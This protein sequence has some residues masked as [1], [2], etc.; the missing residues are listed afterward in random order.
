MR[1]CEEQL[2]LQRSFGWLLTVCS[3]LATI[4]NYAVNAFF[5]YISDTMCKNRLYKKLYN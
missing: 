2:N 4:L 5:F 1:S 3:K